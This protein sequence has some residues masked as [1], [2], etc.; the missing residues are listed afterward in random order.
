[1]GPARKVKISP[2]FTEQGRPAK[3]LKGGAVKLPPK[4]DAKVGFCD[5]RL[6]PRQ[7]LAEKAQGK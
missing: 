1:M 7:T 3:K 6:W 2:T 5:S 4:D